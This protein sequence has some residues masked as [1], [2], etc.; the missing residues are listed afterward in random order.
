MF[1]RKKPKFDASQFDGIIDGCKSIYAE[2]IRPLEEQYLINNFHYPLLNAKDFDAKPLV[3]L[4][5]QYSTGKTSFIKYLLDMEF[6][7]MHIGPEP[8]TDGFQAIMYG[9]ESRALPG[10]AL[11]SNPETPFYELGQFGN[12]FLQRFSGCEVPSNFSRGATLVDTPGVLAGKKQEER[13]YNFLEVV[14]WFAPRADM[15]M[16]MFD[17][18][19][20]DISDEFKKVIVLLQVDNSRA[21]LVRNSAQFSHALP[22]CCRSTRT[23]S[24][25]WHAAQFRR[26]GWRNSAQFSHR[27]SV[28]SQMNKADSMDPAE[29]LKVNS[30]LTWALSRILR[31]PEPRRIYTGSFWD[32]P[33]KPTY[34]SELFEKESASL[35]A[36]L[37]TVP[38]NNSV[39]KVNDLVMRAR[40]VKVQALIFDASRDPVSHTPYSHYRCRRS[41]STR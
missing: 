21:I 6:P 3:L 17:A 26:N 18:N 39:A 36:D 2:K 31:S 24:A 29:L 37:H 1:R 20:V 32:Q 12:S 33:L 4:V 19:K 10:H 35:L 9:G 27:L 41:S 13:S 38:R 23:R 40:M 30:A 5:G 25:S 8:T 28:P 11:V 14:R 34:L 22:S 16:L 7:G 15:I